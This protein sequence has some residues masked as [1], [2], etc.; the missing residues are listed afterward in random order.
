MRPDQATSGDVANSRSSTTP[1]PRSLLR[2]ILGT[3]LDIGQTRLELAVTEIEE[4]RLRLARLALHATFALFFIGLGLML[5]VGAVVLACPPAWRP[6]I[7]AIFSALCLCAGGWAWWRWQ[8]AAARKP[9][10][11]GATLDE[12]SKD[13]QCLKG[14]QP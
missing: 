5:A 11:M 12:L 1:G 4:E 14:A 2:E 13:S 8:Q 6:G 9:S 10:L 7:A 3:L